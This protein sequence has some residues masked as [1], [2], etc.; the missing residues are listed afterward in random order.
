MTEEPRKT[1][2]ILKATGLVLSIL[3]RR[4]KR[5]LAIVLVAMLFLGLLEV[6]G[7][8]SITPFL[9]VASQPTLIETNRYLSLAYE[10]VG[11]PGTGPFIARGCRPG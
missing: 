3:N 9:A 8:G 7:I 2:T 1:T 4:E 6:V 10:A 5:N 11:E